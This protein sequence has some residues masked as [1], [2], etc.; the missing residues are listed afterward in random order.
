MNLTLSLNARN[1]LPHDMA[2]TRKNNRNLQQHPYKKPLFPIPTM[3]AAYWDKCQS[4]YVANVVVMPLVFE[5]SNARPCNTYVYSSTSAVLLVV[6]TKGAREYCTSQYVFTI[7]SRFFFSFPCLKCLQLSLPRIAAH[8]SSLGSRRCR[9]HIVY[10]LSFHDL[11]RRKVH[12]IFLV[13]FLF[14]RQV[15][16][17]GSVMNISGVFTPKEISSDCLKSPVREWK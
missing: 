17:L 16:D 11:Q 13:Y 9:Q 2:L 7:V 14:L 1:Y 12:K 6:I 4:N 3:L 5:N 8:L 10:S 15:S